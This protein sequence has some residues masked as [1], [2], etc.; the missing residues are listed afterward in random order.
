MA[1]APL[2]SGSPDCGDEGAAPCAIF[3]VSL[4]PRTPP[5]GHPGC[6]AIVRSIQHSTPQPEPEHCVLRNAVKM[7]LL[8]YQNVLIQSVLTERFSGYLDSPPIR[9]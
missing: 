4:P 9:A 7:L 1:G 3:N 2:Y 6:H 8:D 5:S